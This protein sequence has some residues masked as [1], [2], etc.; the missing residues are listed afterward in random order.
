MG[1]RSGTDGEPELGH[2]LSR[3]TTQ[4]RSLDLG[5]FT[6]AIAGFGLVVLGVASFSSGH[7]GSGM[8]ADLVL[9]T[10]PAANSKVSERKPRRFL[11]ADS[12]AHLGWF[13]PEVFADVEVLA[14]SLMKKCLLSIG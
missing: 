3:S 13:W 12:G 1:L 11:I 7:T 8:R 6:A 5:D 10:Q 9:D 4:A 14:W 2:Q